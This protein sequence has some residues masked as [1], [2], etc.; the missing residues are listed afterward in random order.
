MG[1]FGSWAGR[2]ALVKAV[3]EAVP[4][5]AM[6]VFKLLEELCHQI[7][8]TIN[9]LWWSHDPKRQKIQ[10]LGMGKLCRQ[11]SKGG[12]RFRD[13]VLFNDVLLVK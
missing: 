13:M 6:S 4:T 3:A 11:K 8:S 9:C 10:W 12:L 1:R 5:Y 2:E 7:Q